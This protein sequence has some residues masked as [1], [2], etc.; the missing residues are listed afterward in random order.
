MLLPVTVPPRSAE[1]LLRSKAEL[2]KGTCNYLQGQIVSHFMPLLTEAQIAQ[3]AANA[4]LGFRWHFW[5]GKTGVAPARKH[6]KMPIPNPGHVLTAQGTH[7]I[8]FLQTT[9][10]QM[11]LHLCCVLRA[12]GCWDWK[13]K[14]YI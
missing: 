6:F 13:N 2:V 1:D 4:A 8:E 11:I 12:W 10:Q 3:E 14:S 9:L 5:K 7:F